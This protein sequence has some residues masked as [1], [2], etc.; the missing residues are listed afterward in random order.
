MV[1]NRME[2]EVLGMWGCPEYMMTVTRLAYVAALTIDKDARKLIED[3]HD[4]LLTEST[5]D[6]YSELYKRSVDH[7]EHEKLRQLSREKR[8]DRKKPKSQSNRGYS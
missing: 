7:H 6:E 3:L 2:M 4:R 1:I 8:Q 5:A